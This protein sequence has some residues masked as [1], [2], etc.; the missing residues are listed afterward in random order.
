M[1]NRREI[2]KVTIYAVISDILKCIQTG[3]E[4]HIQ[5]HREFERKDMDH[6]FIIV[7]ELTCLRNTENVLCHFQ[8]A[9][10]GNPDRYPIDVLEL[11]YR[12]RDERRHG[13]AFIRIRGGEI[14]LFMSPGILTLDDL[15][16]K[17]L[18]DMIVDS[19]EELI[20]LIEK[21]GGRHAAKRTR[22]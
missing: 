9:A 22:K 15:A 3:G 21:S 18:I 19:N 12:N 5:F 16:I 20:N 14:P 4:H 7:D 2:T 11:V 17:A 13:G 1:D 8:I 10:F 6:F